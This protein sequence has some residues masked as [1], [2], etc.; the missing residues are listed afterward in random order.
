MHCDGGLAWALHVWWP[1]GA[2][3]AIICLLSRSVRGL[4]CAAFAINGQKYSSA[5][6]A[7]L[8]SCGPLTTVRVV[9]RWYGMVNDG[10]AR[11]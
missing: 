11:I 1:P 5:W 6:Q 4:A 3:S 2:V 10:V 9:V 8:L 7:S